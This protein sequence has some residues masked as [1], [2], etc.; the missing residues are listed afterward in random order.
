MRRGRRQVLGALSGLMWGVGTAVLINMYGI[1]TLSPPLLY[2]VTGA[3]VIVSWAWSSR[4]GRR[5][6]LPLLLL[7]VLLP[8]AARAQEGEC[9]VGIDP[10]GVPLSG[11]TPSRPI[12][13]DPADEQPVTV[14]LFTSEPLDNR[15]AEIW[16][17]VGG[18]HVPL[19]SGPIS[20]DAFERTFNTNDLLTPF[21][22]LPGLHHV[23]G[24]VDDFCQV[25]GY[26]R[27][28]G[29]PLANPVGASAAAMVVLGLPGTALAGRPLR[30]PTGS[31]TT[32]VESP[33]PA[34][35]VETPPPTPPPEAQPPPT[36]PPEAQPPPS[37]PPQGPPPEPTRSPRRPDDKEGNEPPEEI[38][39]VPADTT[40]WLQA[41]IFD[42]ADR[43]S[44]THF[45]PDTSHDIEVRIGPETMGWLTG[46]EPFPEEQLP[47][48][49]PHRLTIVLTEP[50]LLRTPQVSRIMLPEAGASTSAWFELRTA[51]ETARVD[52]RLIVLFGNRVLHTAR[53]PEY[54]GAKPPHGHP[55]NLTVDNVAE[56]ETVVETLGGTQAEQFDAAFIVNHDAH[57][58]GRVTAIADGDAREVDLDEKEIADAL[59]VFTKR[60]AEVVDQPADYEGV[61]SPGTVELLTF[62]ARHGALLRQFLVQGFLGDLASSARLQVVSARPDAYFPF[63]FAYDYDAPHPPDVTLCAEGVRLLAEGTRGSTCPATHDSSVVCPLGFWGLS[64]TIER[65]TYQHPGRGQPRFL[66]RSRPA[67]GRDR[68]SLDA[69]SMFAASNRVDAFAPGSIAAVAAALAA[70]SAGH[71]LRADSWEEWIA[72]IRA[73]RPALMVLLPHTV[74]DDTSG[75]FGLEIG[76]HDRCF[77]DQINTEFVHQGDQPVIV[78]LLGCETAVAGSIS[79]ETLPA[80]FVTAGAEIVLATITEVLGR[81]AAPIASRLVTILYEE[82]NAGARTIGDVMVILRRRLLAEGIVAVLAVTAFGD[83][84]WLVEA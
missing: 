19:R 45:R 28:L 50:H 59:D 78:S 23:G 11:T 60:L 17:D 30:L 32:T 43:T 71:S 33:P 58:T 69:G 80:R 4:A 18:V 37:P 68:I 36:P 6:L 64:K 65:R 56:V 63:E 38:P 7:L 42:A 29:N 41:R 10:P 81:H 26:V 84:G 55:A 70:T 53:L 1:A 57:G 13:I 8:V 74:Y 49:G 22:V 39:P 5:T 73:R 44:L 20:G 83:A 46:T 21:G 76:E 82:V 61:S 67:S 34:P 16:L 48:L 3:A 40:R 2:G 72:D 79:F 47:G 12:T 77:A 31:S 9:E 75:F 24:H 27:V 15:H 51:A 54:V 35:P 52:A 66:V 14:F 62:F 25:D